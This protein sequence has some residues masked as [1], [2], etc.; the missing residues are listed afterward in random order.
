MKE[1]RKYRQHSNWIR[2]KQKS[3]SVNFAPIGQLKLKYE[4]SE[5]SKLND[6]SCLQSF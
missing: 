3:L 2:C 4:F 1:L 6:A 5:K